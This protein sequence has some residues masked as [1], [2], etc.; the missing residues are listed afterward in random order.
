[1][2]KKQKQEI[3]Q[4]PV[5]TTPTEWRVPGGLS[6][7][8]YKRPPAQAFNLWPPTPLAGKEPSITKMGVGVGG[9]SLLNL[10]SPLTRTSLLF[11]R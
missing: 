8:R 7:W 5:A 2:G 11:A 9:D 3:S 6:L 1:M 4:M 10:G